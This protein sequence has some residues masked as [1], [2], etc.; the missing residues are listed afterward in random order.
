MYLISLGETMV[1]IIY[2]KG[3]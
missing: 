3:W 1:K 2:K